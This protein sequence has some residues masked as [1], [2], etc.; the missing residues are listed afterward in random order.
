MITLCGRLIHVPMIAHG[1][2]T[3]EEFEVIK[4]VENNTP[5]ALMLGKP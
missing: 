1:S 2:S 5:F 4:F 3:E